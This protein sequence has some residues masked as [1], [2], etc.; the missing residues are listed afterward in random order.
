[1]DQIDLSKIPAVDA[2]RIPVEPID[3]EHGLVRVAKGLAIERVRIVTIGSSTTSGEGSIKPY[4]PRLNAFLAEKYPNARITVANRGHGGK[5]APFE[6]EQFDKDVIPENPDLVIWQVGTNSVWQKPS[7]N[8]PSFE[9]TSK[10]IRDGL[11]R[12]RKETKADVILMDLQYLPGVLTKEKKPKALAMVAEIDRLAREAGVS[13]F[14]RFAFMKG[15]IDV[16]Q[17]SIDRMVSEA[18]DNRLHQSEWMTFRLAWAVKI[19]V[20][21]GVDKANAAGG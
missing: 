5:E 19:A 15:L 7:D 18:D 2:S 17:V 21:K 20:E 10:A 13:V 8:P 6:L 14:R 11:V 16:E 12:L 4:P 3:L 9:Q 1:M